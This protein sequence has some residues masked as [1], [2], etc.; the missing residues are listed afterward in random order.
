MSI[1]TCRK[2]RKLTY[3]KMQTMVFPGG[4]YSSSYSY[5]LHFLQLTYVFDHLKNAHPQSNPDT[6]TSGI[7]LLI[8]TL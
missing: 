3:T 8:Y 7:S 4:H 2:K 6:C 5:I 1:Y